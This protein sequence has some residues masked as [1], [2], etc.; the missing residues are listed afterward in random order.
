MCCLLAGVTCCYFVNECMFVY[1]FGFALTSPHLRASIIRFI[2]PHNKSV[3]DNKSSEVKPHEA[4]L[5]RSVELS[6]T[7]NLVASEVFQL[8]VHAGIT[9]FGTRA[10]A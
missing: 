9:P 5:I 10:T 6:I 7:P 8:L 2:L 4:T 1:F 3:I